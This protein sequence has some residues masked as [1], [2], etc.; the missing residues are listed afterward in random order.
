MYQRSM[1]VRPQR[2]ANTRGQ[3]QHCKVLQSAETQ[4]RTIVK[5]R[6][7]RRTQDFFTGGAVRPICRKKS[8]ISKE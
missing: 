7:T 2:F 1:D 6:K 4:T 5:N 8:Q 3:K